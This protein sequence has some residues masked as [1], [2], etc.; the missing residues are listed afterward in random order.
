M[1]PSS[2]T[3][4]YLMD[5]YGRATILS[6]EEHEWILFSEISFNGSLTQLKLYRTE[7]VH[8]LGVSKST[9]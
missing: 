8:V 4:L 2:P 1:G 9:V 6:T 7:C 3:T 5:T